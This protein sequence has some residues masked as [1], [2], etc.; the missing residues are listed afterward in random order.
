MF[1]RWLYV[2]GKHNQE[3]PFNC[4]SAGKQLVH[5]IGQSAENNISEENPGLRDPLSA[6]NQQ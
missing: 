4:L 5:L 6:R 1:K 2:I 3:K